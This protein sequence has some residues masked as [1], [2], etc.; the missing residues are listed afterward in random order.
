MMILLGQRIKQIR[1]SLRL[2]QQALAENLGVS[3]PSISQIENGERKVC[4]EELK[5]LAEIFN[6]SA[7]ALLD[8]GKEPQVMIRERGE[9]YRSEAVSRMRINVP[10]KNLQKFKEVL[11]YILN[12]VGAK[13]SIGEAVIY[14]LLYFIDFDYY[15]KHEEQLIGATYLKNKYGPTPLEFR[16]IVDQMTAKRDIME[17]KDEYFKYPQRKY[18]PLRKPDLSILKGSEIEAINDVLDRLSDMNARQISDYSHDDV[19]WLTAE[20][21]KVIEYEAVFY[22][23]PAYSVREYDSAL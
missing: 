17:V 5:K 15:E 8:P 13:P 2:S 22:R 11:I 1:E 4:A 16:K 14:K 6:M 3:R 20:E 12:K 7:D 19:P 23:T 10:Q 9:A 18:L 21:G